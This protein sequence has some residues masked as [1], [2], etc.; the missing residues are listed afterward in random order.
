MIVALR[1]KNSLAVRAW[2]ALA[3]L[4]ALYSRKQDRSG[5]EAQCLRWRRRAVWVEVL[6][7]VGLVA[8]VVGTTA[9]AWVWPRV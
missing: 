4:A 5:P 1:Q 9:I 2:P 7:R 3:E 8:M 6:V